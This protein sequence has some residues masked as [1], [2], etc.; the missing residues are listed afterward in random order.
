M[1]GVVVVTRH[2]SLVAI[3]R[4]KAGISSLSRDESEKYFVEE[5][6]V[7]I[8]LQSRVEK[9][10]F[11]EEIQPNGQDQISSVAIPRRKAGISSTTNVL[12]CYG[13][14]SQTCCNPA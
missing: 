8:P 11:Q 2:A 13:C 14:L 4:R 5:E 12:G 3:P 9:Q 7:A 6:K 1:E 10:A